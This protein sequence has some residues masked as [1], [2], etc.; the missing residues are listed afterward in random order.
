MI[1]QFLSPSTCAACKGCCFFGLEDS[2]EMPLESAPSSDKDEVAYCRAYSDSGCVLGGEKP[3]E[4]A[5]YPFRVMRLGERMV[6]AVAQYC[7]ETAKA[8]LKTLCD[9]AN[10]NAAAM[11]EE[12]ARHPESVKPYKGD[13]VILK[14]I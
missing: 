7:P 12:T 13:Y 4:C 2:W 14:V 11:L 6:I 9:F 10:E 5:L 1:K 8:Q 3:F